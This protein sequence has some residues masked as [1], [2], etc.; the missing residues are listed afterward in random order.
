MIYLSKKLWK[1]GKP[2]FQTTAA[3]T[4]NQNHYVVNYILNK[5]SGGLA[6]HWLYIP[7][8]KKPYFL[9]ALTL[10]DGS[11]Y[12]VRIDA[13]AVLRFMKRTP[14]YKPNDKDPFAKEAMTVAADLVF[15]ILVDANYVSPSGL[16]PLRSKELIDGF[17]QVKTFIHKSM[18]TKRQLEIYKRGLRRV[19]KEAEPFFKNSLKE[20]GIEVAGEFKIQ[21]SR[22]KIQ[23]LGIP[24]AGKLQID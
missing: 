4:I 6:F 21:D 3:Y 24:L 1:S 12:Y 7:H 9:A 14:G 10:D 23:D 2:F 18:F 16:W 22:F 13:H 15:P 17:L 19:S 5:S 20:F 8:T 11:R